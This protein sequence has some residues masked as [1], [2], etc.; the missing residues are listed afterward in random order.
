[1]TNLSLCPDDAMSDLLATV[2]RDDSAGSRQL[3]T[4]LDTYPADPR[5]HFLDGSLLAANRDYAAAVKAMRRAVDMAPDY[6]LARFQLGFLQ[7][8]SGEPYA[9]QESWGPLH[10]LPHDNYLR[11]FVEGLCHLIRDEFA[12]AIGALEKGIG[13]NVEN[14]PMNNDMRLIV[15]EI[16]ARPETNA[17][18]SDVSPS[19][20]AQMLLQQA[21][22]KTT[23][24]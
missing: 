14:P 19:S 22:L 1:M 11:S 8:S 24:H 13:Q 9:A 2:D 7:L 12:D 23:R 20:A 3:R 17:E 21:A 18:A 10:G 6:A 4:L 16:R 5:L 15:N